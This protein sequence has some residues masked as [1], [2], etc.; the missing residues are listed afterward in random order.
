[1][2]TMSIPSVEPVSAVEFASDETS[3]LGANGCMSEDLEVLQVTESPLQQLADT[4][5]GILFQCELSVK[6]Q[7]S[8][9]YLSKGYQDILG[10][11]DATLS[12]PVFIAAIHPDDRPRVKLA[13]AHSAKTLTLLELDWRMRGPDQSPKWV[14]AKA[15]P[16]KLTDGTIRW[17]GILLDIS[18]RKQAEPEKPQFLISSEE[19]I[20]EKAQEKL[21]RTNAILKA[22]QDAVPDGILVIDENHQ[23]ASFNRNFSDMWCIPDV[24]TETKD[25]HQLWHFV[26]DQLKN[27]EELIAQIEYLD[28]HPEEKS[29]VEVHLKDERIFYH[30]SAPI[31][32]LDSSKGLGRIWYFRDITEQRRSEFHVKESDALLKGVV[33]GT[34]DLIFVKDLQGKYLLVNEA[35]TQMFA[36]GQET[37]L[38]KD[39]TYLYPPAIAKDIQKQERQLLENQLPQTFEQTVSV[40]GQLRTFLTSKTPYQDSENNPIGF[41][42]ISR[43]ITELQQV[44]E[45]RDRLFQFSSDM[46]CTAGFDGYLKHT[47]P[48]F[49][50]LLGYSREELLAVPFIRFI[51]PDDQ[52]VSKQVLA[53]MGR[54]ES[55]QSFENRWQCKNGDYRWFSWSVTPY[56]QS[57]IFYA[58]ARDI[59]ERRQTEAALKESEQ[60]FR[61]VTEAAGEY[62]WEINAEGKYTFLTEKVKAVKGYS[63]ADLIGRALFTTMFPAD[64]ASVQSTLQTA[65]AQKTSF[66]LEYRGI[67]PGGKIIW[68]EISG[69]PMLNDRGK[70]IGF[71]G[72]GLSISA[73]KQAEASLRL[74]KQ[75][76][77]S[78]SDAICITDAD[79]EPVY[80]NKAF[81]ELFEIGDSQALAAK[82]VRRKM[83]YV[84]PQVAQIVSNTIQ[85]GQSY[86]GEVM[87]RSF[88]GRNISTLLRANIICDEE[89][90]S[91]GTIRAYTDISDRK[92]A[93]AQLKLQEEF[94]R[95]IYDGVA[96]HIFALNVL[97]DGCIVYSAHNRAAEKATG[98]RSKSIAGLTPVELFGAKEGKTIEQLCQH[99]IDFKAPV[100]QEESITLNGQKTWVLTTFTPLPDEA[101]NIHR[102][103]GTCFDITPI[104]LAEAEL[105]QQAQ[106]SAF[107]AEIDSLL[108]RGED[109]RTMLQGCCEVIVKYM[110]A[111]FAR[112]WTLNEVANILELQ[113]SAGLYTR[114]NGNHA[115]VP[116][117]QFKIGLIAAE[118]RAY[119]TNNLQNS[120]RMNDRVWAKREG[121]VS[122]AGY[123]LILDGQ[124]IGVVALFSHHCLSDT[125][126]SILGMVADEMALGVKRKQTE[127]QLQLS[128]NQL[129]QQAR[130][131]QATLQELQRTQSHLVQSEKMSSL[132]QLVAGVAHEINN[133]VNFIYGNL[134][135][136]KNYAEDLLNLIG[137]YQFHF[138]VSP[139]TIQKA[140]DQMDLEFV[141]EDLPKLLNSMKVGSERI[142]GIVSSL[143]IFSRMDESEMKAVNLHDGLES[144]LMIL[145]NR[146]KAGPDDKAITVTR[147]YS[148]LPQVECYV[149]QLNQVFMNVLSNA[150]DALEDIRRGQDPNKSSAC[151]H[152]QTQLTD[153][154]QVKIGIRD[155]G[156]GIPEEIQARLF[157]PFFTTKPI[158]K[159]T[160]MG[161]SISYQIVTEKHKG[162]LTC[163]SQV[164]EGTTFMIAIPLKQSDVV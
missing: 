32:F 108:T 124:L 14:W 80:H 86:A 158:G 122:F 101:G 37:L 142:Q 81:A 156:P 49:S 41:V 18:D 6:K 84:D 22:Q 106:I 24:L 144:T 93:E 150:I 123:P 77:E 66:R 48:A 154:Y 100:T 140:A 85:Q 126:L 117:G 27:P 46:V 47:N 69:L 75:A 28:C 90:N 52:A 54:G 16:E 67:T 40:G 71:R 145:Q 38:G 5:P 94:L 151:I 141:M 164:G 50:R 88:Q 78:S 130:E 9:P 160:G 159:G 161:L 42:G 113:A 105:K 129:R 57:Q 104:K 13:I 72:T 119:L 133:P 15:A 1:M 87:M 120:P 109:L 111:A 91:V 149:G 103:I 61:D 39:D 64:I 127:V 139:L 17:H 96:H 89:G 110:Q 26:I 44:R 11:T 65:S 70:V 128:E 163:D 147:D 118:K 34:N 112:V 4:L 20:N 29:Q 132:G 107:R 76:V 30:S 98:W 58:T 7:L 136:A 83:A 155:N 10:V 82:F 121:L 153:H 115:Q 55:L 25:D 99:C 45:E 62:V 12:S 125:A 59:T 97:P 51:H 33:N 92:A 131:L 73:K 68:E 146:L 79:L 43:D 152:I 134:A 56:T 35:M 157:D 31:S 138:P 116:V 23:V 36:N 162:Y 60:R 137:L 143:R 63:A 74:F 3:V 53:R 114:I 19:R 2:L 95:S 102:I 21:R 135:H 8:F 148:N